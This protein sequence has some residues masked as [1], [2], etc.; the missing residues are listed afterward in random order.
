MFK[1]TKTIIFDWD[2]TLHESMVIYYD[3]FTVAYNHLVSRGY[4]KPRSFSKEEVSKFLGVNPKDMWTSVLPTLTDQIFSEASQMVSD[5]MAKAI[6]EKKAR[7][8]PHAIEVLQYLKEKGYVLVYLSNSK[9]YYM[10]A[11]RNAFDLDRFFSHYFV[12]EMYQYIPKKNILER[13]KDQLKSPMVMIG[14]RELD[15]ETGRYNN[16]K[17]IGCSYGYGS[18]DEFKD[19]DLVISDLSEVLSLF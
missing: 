3:A 14:D 13:V 17:T 8:Y 4:A 6:A 2:G 19:A 15:I 9:N 1:D 10:D 5:A 18:S 11:M 7:L 12:S 16:I